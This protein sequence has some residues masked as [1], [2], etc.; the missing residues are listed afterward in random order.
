MQ[1]NG[2]AARRCLS[3]FAKN[4]RGGRLDAPPPARRGLTTQDSSLAF[5]FYRQQHWVIEIKFVDGSP[6]LRFS[7]PSRLEIN[8]GKIRFR[9]FAI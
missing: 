8:S 6:G 7:D 2:G 1:K 5:F 4:I 3:L 9:D